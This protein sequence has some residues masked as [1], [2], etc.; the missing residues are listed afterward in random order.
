MSVLRIFGRAVAFA[1]ALWSFTAHGQ[2][3]TD[4]LA[5]KDA[6]DRGDRRKL[7]QLAAGFGG[8]LLEPY[9]AFWQLRLR[10]DEVPPEAVRAYLAR[11][12]STPLAERLRI[13]W[14]KSLARRGDWTRF[15]E[16]LND[17]AR[18]DDVELNCLRLQ[19]R[20]QL[21]GDAVLAEAKRYWF[22]GQTTPDACEPLFAALA[23]RGDLSTADRRARYRLAL[24]AGNLRLAQNVAGDLP[25]NERITAREFV[26]A[27]HD[28]AFQL[29]KGQFAWKTP[30]GRDLALY[31]LERVA[32]KDAELAHASWARWR[33]RMPPADRAWGDARVAYHA[34]RQLNPSA[35]DWFDEAREVTL[36]GDFAAWR[37]RAA[38]RAHAWNDVRLAI[39]AMPPGDQDDP[40]W[41]YW[42]A[43][44]LA[45]TGFPKTA[46]LWFGEL[47]NDVNFYGFL[48]AD[49]IGSGA[50]NLPA[51]KRALMPPTQEDVERFAQRTAVRRAVKLAQLDLRPEHLREWQY[52]VRGLDDEGLLVAAEY[53]RRIGLYDRAIYS[54]ERTL[55][56]HDYALRYMTPFR[57]EFAAAARN[58]GIDEELLYGVARQESRFT[59]GII[60]S[61]GAVGLMQLMPATARW[62]AKQLARSDYTPARISAID[63]NTQFGAYYFKY[64]QDRLDGRAVLA[65]A[66]YN[67]GPARAQSWRPSATPIEGAIWVETIP[68]GET[69]DYVKKVLANTMMYARALDR[70][71]VSLT[72]RLG[73][74][75]PRG[76]GPDLLT[77]AP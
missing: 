71:Y 33:E 40:A 77:R 22:T 54:A 19:Y 43:R 16:E 55:E 1:F 70:P 56:R 41:R 63:I 45:Q 46:G 65:A 66:A 27:E 48:A 38:L 61:A 60:S 76:A 23:A 31:V 44:A 14:L 11:F 6:F 8:H 12:A 58:Q 36:G 7:D 52:A 47:A 32:R 69:R 21:E 57:S 4:F 17:L 2:S 50:G 29:A 5:A 72:D 35:N 39:D 25:G 67:A 30:A 75:A 64:C 18:N 34:A 59:P 42:K 9:V 37:V 10:I 74:V 53:A 49:A 73:V 28:P 15:G 62:V 26:H 13:D 3:D 20:R 51:V 68:F 24:E